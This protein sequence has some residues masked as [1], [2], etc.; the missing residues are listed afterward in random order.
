MK[1]YIKFNIRS[2]EGYKADQ[3]KERY[4]LM[5]V[6]DLKRFLEDYDDETEIVTYDLNNGH[7]ASWG[8]ICDD[9]PEEVY[10]EEDEYDA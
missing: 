6:G 10:E 8:L 5:T 2:N 7:G 1:K 4:N 3:V 9:Y